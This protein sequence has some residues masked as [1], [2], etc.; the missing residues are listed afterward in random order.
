MI[1]SQRSTNDDDDCEL[2]EREGACR[3]SG[4]K[5]C[6]EFPFLSR[7]AVVKQLKQKNAGTTREELRFLSLPSRRR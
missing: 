2:F 1:R 6:A 5:A 7:P 4:Y 3:K